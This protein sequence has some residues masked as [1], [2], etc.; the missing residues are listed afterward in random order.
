MEALNKNA[1]NQVPEGAIIF[2]ESD[3]ANYVGLVLRG[4]VQV[5]GRGSKVT[6]GAG[7]FIGV[8]DFATGRYQATYHALDNVIIYVFEV[9]S[10]EDLKKV[11]SAN[12]DYGGLMVASQTRYIKELE[13][14][15]GELED[16]GQ[17]LVTFL[18]QNVY[19]YSKT[20]Y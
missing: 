5:M 14:I 6:A 12:R 15:R 20:T 13:R 17:K 4:R 9:A 10:F 11:V 16:R 3:I 8:A 1:M 7:T 18:N 19:L 2:K